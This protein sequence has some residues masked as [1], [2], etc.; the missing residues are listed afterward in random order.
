[1]FF[2]SLKQPR[3]HLSLTGNG[4][5]QNNYRRHTRGFANVNTVF[6][7][8]L[9]FMVITAQYR[10]HS[11]NLT[12]Q[13]IQ[14]VQ[15]RFKKDSICCV[16]PLTPA[17]AVVVARTFLAITRQAQ[18]LE[19]WPNSQRFREVF[20]FRLQKSFKF[21]FGFFLSVTSQGW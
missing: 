16:N 11:H 1:M 14:V 7:T 3:N 15:L 21:G 18:E 17:P 9:T 10:G 13:K 4:T 19:S 20:Q 5:L 8:L 6:R 12:V 2:I